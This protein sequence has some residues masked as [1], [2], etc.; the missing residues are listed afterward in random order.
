M[1]QIICGITSQYETRAAS[2]RAVR[3]QIAQIGEQVSQASAEERHSASMVER[4]ELLDKKYASDLERLGATSEGISFFEALPN[5]PCPLCGTPAESQVDPSNLRP[6]APRKYRAAIAAEASKILALR[7]GLVSSLTQERNRFQS[8]HQKAEAL[9]SELRGLERRE[10]RIVNAARVEFSADPRTLAERHSELTAQLGILDELDRLNAEIDRLN[11]QKVRKRVPV[12]RDAGS[13]SKAVADIA[14]S[15]L[16]EWGFTDIQSVEVD[17]TECDLR[18]DGRARLSF[19]AGKRAIFLCALIVALLRHA[20][21]NGH[22]H[23]GIAVIDSPLK[24]YADP[25]QED[26]GVPAATVTENFY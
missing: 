2:L 19:G 9:T 14:K 11:A 24:A 3:E 16:S 6:D 5:V 1:P 4:F 18:I 7:E 21:E 8:R 25:T 15:L 10:A 17:T 13:S 26:R 20:M 23:L 22:P 12:A